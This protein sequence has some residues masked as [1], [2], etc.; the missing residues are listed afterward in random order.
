MYTKTLVA[1]AVVLVPFAALI[2]A[3]S[4]QAADPID[5]VTYTNS[6]SSVCTVTKQ[7]ST[8]KTIECDKLGS[9]SFGHQVE[10][11]LPNKHYKVVVRPG[12]ADPCPVEWFESDWAHAAQDRGMLWHSLAEL[13]GQSV[14]SDRWYVG[15][16]A[17]GNYQDTAYVTF[18]ITY[19]G[20]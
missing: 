11:A 3:T 8:Q 6:G 2:P 9:N 5:A 4:A 15:A 12:H 20:K 1:A 7:S 17:A 10:V 19:T 14:K 13:S 16:D 18:V